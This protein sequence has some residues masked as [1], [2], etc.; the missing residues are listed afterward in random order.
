MPAKRPGLFPGVRLML[1]GRCRGT[2]PGKV[3][4]RGKTRT[5]EEWRID[6]TPHGDETHALRHA[7]VDDAVDALGRRHAVDLQRSRDAIDGG[8]GCG[9]L[10]EED[11]GHG[12]TVAGEV[13]TDEHLKADEG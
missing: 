10:T 5:G 1:R 9:E 6:A 12:V 4:I 2:G 8:F 7:R 11:D 3:T 13:A